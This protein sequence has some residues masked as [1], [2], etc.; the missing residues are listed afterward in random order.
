MQRTSIL[1][2]L[3]GGSEMVI[4]KNDITVA[5]LMVLAAAHGIDAITEIGP[6]SE[7]NVN[8]A[9]EYQRLARVYSPDDVAKVFGPNAF[10]V[11][12]P[13]RFSEIN[14]GSDD[15]PEPEPEAPAAPA[16][17]PPRTRTPRPADPPAPSGD[18]QPADSAPAGELP[19]GAGD[20]A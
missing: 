2:A 20:A 12:L 9:N 15:E 4:P 8:H 11:R 18:G 6:R 16:P 7:G 19:L 13:V 5:E 3:G 17:R 14:F 10:G 1:L